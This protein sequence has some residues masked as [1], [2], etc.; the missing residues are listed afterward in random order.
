MKAPIGWMRDFTNIPEGAHAFAEAMTL[1]G[2]KVEGI[3]VTGEGISGV[4]TARVVAVARHPDADRLSVC[5]VDAGGA[6]GAL[7]I[8]TAATNVTAGR[9]IPVALDGA[10]L[11]D[12]KR[13]HRGKLRGIDSEGMM[14]SFQELGFTRSDY[15]EAAEDGIWL[16][17]DATP[18]G[19]DV[20]SLLGLGE[21]IV[22]FEI[23]S[24]RPDCLCI[25]GLAREAAVTIGAPFS[26]CVP[27]V[28][29]DG[30]EQVRSIASV[31][32]EAPDL[33]MRYCAR[34]LRDVKIGPSPDWMRRRL[35]EAGIRPISN[36]V[37][38]TN[39]VM[40]EL[41]QPMHAFDLDRLVDHRIIVRRAR[42]GEPMTTLDGAAHALDS[43]MLVIADPGGPVAL[44]GVMGGEHSEI[45][46]ATTSI[47][48]ES[49]VFHGIRTRL[50]A[51]ALGFRTESSARF[52]KGLD[53]YNAPRALDRAA[54]LV[55]LLGCGTV[56]RGILDEFP[57][58]PD[59]VRV[60][61]RPDR[62]NAFLGT[63]ISRGEMARILGAIGCALSPSSDGKGT[64]IE[65]PTWRADLES[66]ADLAEE[67]ARFH[68]YNLI[69]PSLRSGGESSLGGHTPDQR[70]VEAVKD[71]M[72]ASGFFETYTYSFGSPKQFDRMA[73]PE[74]HADRDCVRILNPLGEDFGVMRTTM[75]DSLL[76][77]AALNAGRSNPE[78]RIFEVSR[79]YR[80]SKTSLDGLPDEIP[81]LSAAIYLAGKDNTSSSTFLELKGALEETA[82]HLGIQ[83]LAFEP[84]TDHPSLHPGRSATVRIG[85]M[86]CGF[87]GTVHPEV[88]ATYEVPESTVLASIRID[89]LIGAASARRTAKPM[90]RFP[91]V[92]RDIALLAE[93]DVPVG[94]LESLIRDSAGPLLESVALFDVYQGAQVKPGC[95]SVAFGLVF[96]A[97]DRTLKEEEVSE[98]VAA[99]LSQLEKETGAELRPA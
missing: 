59:P 70:V 68:G 9:V 15:P 57:T 87:L 11:A 74:G 32:I 64:D 55:E 38:I 40:L 6:H 66:E 63:E 61:F 21:S 45:S 31:T 8:V 33:C 71:A 98:A 73:L 1:S 20:K 93:V 92:S 23:T 80:P 60:H 69:P 88:A 18:V 62:I 78:L 72:V 42:D 52:E 58:V 99:V 41:G 89:A 2:S 29:E 13:I 47:L 86:A 94:R 34:V 90:P 26:P 22:D 83:T 76:Q 51:K 81:Q 35:R 49:A 96:R 16:L 14:C 43:S 30:P 39:Y 28:R 65:P 95:K 48:L 24:N 67:I 54:E 75:V 91:S 37:D 12:G 3:A 36:I 7:T 17:D 77:V 19:I 84:L 79:I 85:G 44:A 53:V 56:C 97:P 10:T 5:T 25:E 46:S 50:T 4:V 27:S 82:L